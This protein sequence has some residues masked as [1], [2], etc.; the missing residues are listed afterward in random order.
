MT[1][2]GGHREDEMKKNVFPPPVDTRQ[3]AGPEE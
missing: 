1:G 2:Q 3:D